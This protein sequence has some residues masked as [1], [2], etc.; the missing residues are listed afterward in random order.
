MAIDA[1]ETSDPTILALIAE[2]TAARIDLLASVEELKDQLTP[3]AFR[4]RGLSL[5][6][7]AFVD[8]SGSVRPKRV[9]VVAGVL[10]GVVALKVF[11]RIRRS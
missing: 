5:V 11:G 4:R 1:V 10:V 7:G 9:A 8:D 3:A 2:I 6:T